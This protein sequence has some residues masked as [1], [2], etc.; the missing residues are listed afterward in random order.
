M[1]FVQIFGNIKYIIYK[2]KKKPQGF[3]EDLTVFYS[4]L[5]LKSYILVPLRFILYSDYCKNLK[6]IISR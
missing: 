4:I 6:I 2:Y 3:L 1:G 5:C